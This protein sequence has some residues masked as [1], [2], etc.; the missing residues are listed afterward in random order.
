MA[1]L[2]SITAGGSGGIREGGTGTGRAIREAGWAPA[3][4][5]TGTVHTSGSLGLAISPDHCDTAVDLQR[6]A[7]L[8]L[9]KSKQEGGGSVVRFERGLLH[10]YEYRQRMEAEFRGALAAGRIDLVYQ[11]IVDLMTGEVEAVEAL[12][13][14][15][16][17]RGAAISP[18]YFIPLAEQC[19][20]I[21]GVGRCLLEKAL[22]ETKGWINGGRIERV[23][24]NVSPLELLDDQFAEA[25]LATLKKIGVDPHFLLL[26]ITEGVMIQ[27]LALVG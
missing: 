17:T 22:L 6:Y 14:W 9:Y 13:R 5:A 20:I 2:S 3:T 4:A 19:G 8:A 21:R 12:A 10:A 27:D 16:D 24:F 25:V 26:E 15:T 23:S 18:T 11:P 7:D 1:R